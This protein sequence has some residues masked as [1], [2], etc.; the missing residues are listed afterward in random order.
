MINSGAGANFVSRHFLAKIGRRAI[1][2]Q[3]MK[4][5]KIDSKLLSTYGDI[6]LGVRVR[7]DF[8]KTRERT[9]KFFATDLDIN[10]NVIL[11]WPWL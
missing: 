2:S 5:K 7:D 4:V 8:G 11:G 10:Y 6:T 3:T 1:R 9:L